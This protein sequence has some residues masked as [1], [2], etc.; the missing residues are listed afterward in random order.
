MFS[1]SPEALL[2]TGTD[3]AAA[4]ASR[5]AQHQAQ[6]SD[7]ETGRVA[8]TRC[9]DDDTD[10]PDKVPSPTGRNILP[11]ADLSDDVRH[12]ATQNDSSRDRTR[13]GM[14]ETP[15]GILSP[16]RLPIPP[17]GLSR[18]KLTH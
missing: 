1:D 5:G 7:R 16:V 17:L 2:A 3:D 14:R 13:T 10:D 15:R 18:V 6:Q 11:L 4:D 12:D 9:D 8:V